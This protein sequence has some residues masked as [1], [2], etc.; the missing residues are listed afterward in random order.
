MGKQLL[1][2]NYNLIAQYLYPSRKSQGLDQLRDHC[3]VACYFLV[4]GYTDVCI[5]G[6]VDIYP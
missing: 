5:E 6:E 4:Q 2:S 3:L 1:A